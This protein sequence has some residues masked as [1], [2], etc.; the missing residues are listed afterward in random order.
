MAKVVKLI[1]ETKPEKKLP[2]WKNR[3]LIDAVKDDIVQNHN[4]KMKDQSSKS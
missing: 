4:R 2:A 3:A 1:P